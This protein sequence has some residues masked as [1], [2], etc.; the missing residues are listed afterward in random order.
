MVPGP[1]E[2]DALLAASGDGGAVSGQERRGTVSSSVLNLVMSA[3]GAGI[4]SMPYSLVGTGILPGIGFLVLTVR[5]GARVW[6]VRVL[7]SWQTHTR[8]HS[9]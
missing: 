5:A 4:L 1:R 2:T 7:M 9:H 6:H 8:S 3:I